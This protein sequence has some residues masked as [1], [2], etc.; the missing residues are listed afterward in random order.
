MK[1]GPTPDAT[2]PQRATLIR[3]Q[4][5]MTVLATFCPASLLDAPILQLAIL[6]LVP[7][8]AMAHVNMSHVLGA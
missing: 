8:T 7:T 5:P 6:I 3:T 2:I 4:H 1:R